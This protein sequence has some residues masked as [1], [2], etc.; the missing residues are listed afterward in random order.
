MQ[1]ESFIAGKER[2][3]GQP[4]LGPDIAAGD[5]HQW[6]LAAYGKLHRNGAAP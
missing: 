3:F 1:S 6:L 2:F 4:A 5:M